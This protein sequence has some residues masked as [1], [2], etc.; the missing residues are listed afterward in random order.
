M[1]D[2]PAPHILRGTKN[3]CPSVAAMSAAGGGGAGVPVWAGC[4]SVLELKVVGTVSGYLASAP[5][6]VCF[7][8]AALALIISTCCLV[9][10][11]LTVGPSRDCVVQVLCL[12]VCGYVPAEYYC[13]W[14]SKL[15]ARCRA[16]HAQCNRIATVDS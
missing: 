16:C 1:S 2:T 13:Q 3:A 11:S 12:T 4:V 8:L 15:C 5:A 9:D 7:D 10:G 14:E 6:G